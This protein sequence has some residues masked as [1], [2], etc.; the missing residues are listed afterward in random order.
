MGT[1]CVR[2]NEWYDVTHPPAENHAHAD[3][4]HLESGFCGHEVAVEQLGE[5][6]GFEEQ[7]VS[8]EGTE[9]DASSNVKCR[10]VPGGD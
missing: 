4:V 3:V 5:R 6:Y 8:L 1:V 2:M 10:D 7:H 9:V